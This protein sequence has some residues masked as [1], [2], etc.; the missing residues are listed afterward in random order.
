MRSFGLACVVVGL[1]AA[2][3]LTS[4]AQLSTTGTIEVRVTDE[5]KGVL[6]GVTLTLTNP[7]TGF[8]RNAVSNDRGVFQFLLVPVGDNYELRSELTGDRKSVV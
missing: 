6:P 4:F 7:T 2:L 1:V 3:P 8:S 5:S